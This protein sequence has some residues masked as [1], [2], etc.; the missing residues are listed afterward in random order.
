MDRII[1]V[2]V[3]AVGSNDLLVA[4]SPELK[5]L[6]VHARSARELDER[7]PGAIQELL[8]AEGHTVDSVRT[9]DEYVSGE[10]DVLTRGRRFQAAIA[11]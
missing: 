7:I 6:Y 10:S 8:E 4:Y 2:N 11:A 1:S 5:G 3:R 9:L